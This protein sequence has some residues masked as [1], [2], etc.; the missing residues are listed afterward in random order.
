MTFKLGDIVRLNNDPDSSRWAITGFQKNTRGERDVVI[1]RWERLR[2]GL[3][4]MPTSFVTSPHGITLLRSPTFSIGQR[5]MLFDGRGTI[6][7]MTEEDLFIEIEREITFRDGEHA[8]HV[9]VRVV[10][11][12][13]I[14]RDN[15]L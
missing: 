15:L 2:R 8:A 13:Q 5:V 3:P 4:K 1:S 7:K 10:G 14:S 9:G 11:R 6:I 12:G